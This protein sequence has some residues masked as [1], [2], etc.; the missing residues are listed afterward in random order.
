MSKNC[1]VFCPF[2]LR[3]R[4]GVGH[5]DAVERILLEAVD[6][7]RR[8][9]AKDFIDGRNNVVDVVELGARRRVGLDA[10]RPGHGHRLTDAAEIGSLELGAFVRRAAGPCPTRVIHVVGLRTAEHI[11]AAEIGQC[12]EVL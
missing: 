2:G 4:K 9:D 5:A 6:H 12:R 3:I 11:H 1:V 10:L 7:A 8:L